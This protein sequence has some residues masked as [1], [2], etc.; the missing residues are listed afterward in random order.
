M[1][2]S[3]ANAGISGSTVADEPIQ[4]HPSLAAGPVSASCP[5]ATPPSQS[6]QQPPPHIVSASTADA[7][8][9][10]AV[11]V[12]VVA[13]SEGVNLDSS[14]RESGDDSEDESEILE[15]SPCGRWLKRR[16]EVDQRDVPGIDCV[17]LAMDTEE[18]VEVVW[19]EV[20]YASLQE[21]KS[22]EEKMRQ[23]FDNLLQLD[24]QNIVKFHR[25]WT[26]TQQAERPRVVFITE[27]MSSGSLKQF[28]KRTKRNA[29]R[30]PLESWRRWCTQILSALSYLHSCSPPIIHG[31]LT[32]DSIFIQHNGLVKIGSVVPDAVH[33]SVRRGR[34]RERERERGAHYFQAPEYGAADQL[35]AA[36]DIYAFGM[37]ALEMAALEIQ[38]S[39]SESTAINEE[40]IQR[41]IFSLEND[42]QRDLIRK[43]LN[44]QPQDR[45]SANDLLF[46]PL[47]F[48]VHSL[49]LLTAHCLVFSPANRT[50]FSETA[51]DG[52]MQ[53]Y[54]QP[55]VVMA[56]LRLAG[57]QERQY[58]LADVS[59]ADKLEKFV[60][61]VK[62]GVYPLITYSGKKPPNFRSRA[63]SPE[64]ADSVKSATPEPVDTESRRIV[65]MMCSVKIKEDSNDI[66]MTILLRM[67]DKMNRQLTC[68]VNENDTAADLTSELVRLGFVHLDDQDKIQVLLEETLKA[69]VMSDGAGAESSGAGVTTT[70]TMA[71]LEQLERNWSISSDADKQGTA[72]MY[73]PQEQQNADGDVD[74]EHSGTTSN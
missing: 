19:N 66:T 33:Y 70:A 27:Y 60:E 74:V 30:L 12:G 28:L 42:L 53:R 55:D 62:Y 6:T 46:H 56:Q 51:F 16:E 54:Y 24:H 50:M 26:D 59:G 67:D 1:S 44:P 38:P 20:Q 73:V 71:A 9:S 69:G 21:L 13:G 10:A 2:N 31:N 40:T 7:G 57:G 29:K 4:H 63:A 49:K 72:V 23:V 52:L 43:C 45:P 22:Q 36:L 48:E 41:T 35:T 8:S 18:G 14:P 61:D 64:R 11:G 25:Y 39:N 68:Q 58:R 47:L 15:E 65:N 37:C 17:H 5:A 32:C 3:Q 34:E